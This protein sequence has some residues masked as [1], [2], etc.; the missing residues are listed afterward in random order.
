[1]TLRSKAFI[2]PSEIDIAF[3][4]SDEIKHSWNE[5][6]MTRNSPSRGRVQHRLEAKCI[7]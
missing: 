5:G 3:E 6:L 1:M 7:V 2:I 4:V